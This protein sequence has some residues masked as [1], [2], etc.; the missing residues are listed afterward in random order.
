LVVDDE[1]ANVELLSRILRRHYDVITAASGPE[2]LELIRK[3]S[4]AA[5]ISDQRMP[6][7]SGTEFLAQAR[8]LVPETVRMILTGYSAEQESLDAINVAHVST[9][10]TKPIVLDVFERAVSDAVHVF[11]LS[12]LNRSLIEEISHKNA[13]LEEA[14]RLLELSLDERTRQLLEANRRLESLALRDSLTGLYNHRFLHERLVEEIARTKRYGSAVCLVLCDIDRFRLYNEAHGHPEGDKLLTL[15]A[16]LLTG[17]SR[18]ADV[19]ARIRP[20]D[21]VAR[22]GGEEFALIVPATPKAGAATM[23]ERIRQTLSSARFP[24]AEVLPGQRVTMSFGVAESPSDADA[25]DKL[26]EAAET[27]L[28]RAKQGGRDRVEVY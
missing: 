22:F 13:E 1:P 28:V 23:C 3:E 26:L 17:A 2:A 8:K 12:L 20:T 25:K 21:M 11:E 19:V 6:G 16:R 18:S 27:A 4:F 10:L 15:I 14:K 5:I 9:F 7:M 24:G